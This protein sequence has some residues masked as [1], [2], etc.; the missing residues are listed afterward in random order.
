MIVRIDAKRLTDAAGML[1]ALGEAFGF[2]AKNRD[3]LADALTHLDD[4]KSGS[5]R[6]FPGETILLAIDGAADVPKAAAQV[7]QLAEIAAFANWR[8]LEKGQPPIL[9]MAYEV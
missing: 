9:A 8:R 7:K 6:V 3:A 1:A 5:G 4:A 2:T